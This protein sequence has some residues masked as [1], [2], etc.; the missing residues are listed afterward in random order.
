MIDINDFRSFVL[1]VANKVGF[2]DNI[3]PSNFNMLAKR[4]LME[5]TIK[6]TGNE[7]EYQPG[8]PIPRKTYEAT[9]RIMENLKHLK[10]PHE[11]MAGNTGRIPI[12]DGTGVDY[13]GQPAGKLFYTSSLRLMFGSDE[14]DAKLMTDEE[15]GKIIGSAILKPTITHPAY[16]MYSDYVQVFPKNPFRV[17]WTYLRY[18]KTPIWAYTLQN[19][20]PVYDSSLSTDLDAPEDAENKIA[21]MMLSYLGINMREQEVIAYSEMKQDKGV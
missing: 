15:M 10:V 2:R 1:F 4:A 17:K 18:P 7:E 20:R 13:I 3:T 11:F 8:R 5:W 16:T 12:P 9:K 6:Q 14:Y 19:G 21:M